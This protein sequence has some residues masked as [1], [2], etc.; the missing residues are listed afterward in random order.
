VLGGSEHRTSAQLE[1]AFTAASADI[2]RLVDRKPE[3]QD[4]HKRHLQ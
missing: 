2:Q 3:L 1:A 4:T